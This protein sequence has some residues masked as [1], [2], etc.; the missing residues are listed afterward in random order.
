MK[1]RHIL[2]FALLVLYSSGCSTDTTT[3]TTGAQSKVEYN[4]SGS[5]SG[6]FKV[7]GAYPSQKD[8]SGA[9]STLSADRKTITISAIDWTTANSK[10]TFIN[11]TLTSNQAIADNQVFT[12]VD[13]NSTVS[14][15]SGY[16]LTYPGFTITDTYTAVSGSVTLTTVKENQIKGTFNFVTKNGAGNTVTITDGKLDVKY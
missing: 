4:Y 14:V 13:P 6:A 9:S 10:A 2:A 7:E 12:T 3:D 15:I 11:F 1:F 16:N 8:G 5:E